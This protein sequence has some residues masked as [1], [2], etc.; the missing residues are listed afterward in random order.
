MKFIKS[1]LLTAFTLFCI[2]TFAGSPSV[3]I[4]SASNEHRAYA[5]LVWT[6]KEKF[7][8]VPDA[9]VGFRSLRVKSSDSVSGGDISARITFTNGPS[10]D[11]A[12]LSYVGGDRDI[13]GNLGVGYSLANSSAFGTLAIQGAYLRG[14]TD[15]EFT[16]K[17]FVPYVEALTVD[18]PK[19]IMPFNPSC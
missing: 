3:T 18:K 10:F 11:S 16:N 13:I 6:L 9:T 19:K 15:F 5:G 12:R 4:P 7:S 8:V 17:R 2:T 14:G 1:T